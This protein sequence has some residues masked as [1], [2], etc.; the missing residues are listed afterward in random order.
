M[1]DI[2]QDHLRGQ[3]VSRRVRLQTALAQ[4]G[5]T[6]Q[7]HSLLGEVDAALDRLER[8][9]YG[10]CD[11]CGDPIEPDRLMADP[12]LRLCLDH[13]TLAEQQALQRDLDLAAR[14]QR[15]LLPASSQVVPGWRFAYEYHPAGI[16]SG[17]YCDVMPGPS[18]DSYFLLGDV[19]G[20]GVAASM[21]M[22]QLHGMF[23]SLVPMGLGLGGLVERASTIFCDSTLP[24]HYATL[25]SVRASATGSIEVC[26]AGHLPLMLVQPQGVTRIGSNSLPIGM[27]CSTRYETTLAT[28][29]P[30]DVLVA[31]TDGL[32]EAED[33]EGSDLGLDRL[34][35][36]CAELAK[37]PPARVAAG[38]IDA[39][40]RFAGDSPQA[41][42]M[43]VLVI[44]R[45]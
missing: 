6:D 16:V 19:A 21:L 23:R 8:G 28:L 41:D 9:N 43:T 31:F 38:L 14:I 20:K 5:A 10:L 18:G 42:D 44:A 33:A 32:S 35:A 40:R 11:A 1:S 7:L 27:F 26:N 2:V 30:G 34:E 45:A 22:T 17:D 29:A 37:E 24:S 13:L 36:R 39:V 15:G 3:L 12:L 4:P 25:A